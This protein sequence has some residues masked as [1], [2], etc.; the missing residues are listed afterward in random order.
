MDVVDQLRVAV[1]VVAILTAG[2]LYVW[3]WIRYYEG[4][5]DIERDAGWHRMWHERIWD[6]SERRE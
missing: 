4:N 3:H 5:A 1:V 6:D 2:A